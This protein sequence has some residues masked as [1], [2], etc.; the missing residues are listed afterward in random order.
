MYPNADAGSLANYYLVS[1]QLEQDNV[2]LIAELREIIRL[3]LQ[4]I[5]GGLPAIDA[6]LHKRA[7]D[8]LE[9]SEI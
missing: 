1:R 3:L 8:A 9:A 7:M 6:E 2:A 4:E 5:D